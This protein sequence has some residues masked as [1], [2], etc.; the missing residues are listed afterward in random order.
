L[1]GLYFSVVMALRALSMSLLVSTA[2]ATELTSSSWDAAVSGKSVFIKF[3][4]PW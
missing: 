1:C 3:Q 2:G 4:A